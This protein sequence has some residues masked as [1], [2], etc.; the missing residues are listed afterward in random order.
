MPSSEDTGSLPKTAHVFDFTE[1]SIKGKICISENLVTMVWIS[2]EY[3]SAASGPH[4]AVA[5]SQ[6]SLV[7]LQS[8][9]QLPAAFPSLILL[10]C[11]KKMSSWLSSLLI[12]TN[13]QPCACSVSHLGTFHSN[14]ETWT[15]ISCL[16]IFCCHFQASSIWATSSKHIQE[17][18]S[19]TSNTGKRFKTHKTSLNCCQNIEG[20]SLVSLRKRQAV[21]Q[22][23]SVRIFLFPMALWETSSNADSW[24]CL[25]TET[26]VM[27]QVTEIQRYKPKVSYHNQSLYHSSISSV[28]EQARVFFHCKHNN[29]QV[30]LFRTWDRYLYWSFLNKE[31]SQFQCSSSIFCRIMTKPLFAL[32][33]LPRASKLYVQVGYLLFH[34][35]KHL[36]FSKVDPFQQ[37][38]FP[39]SK[40]NFNSVQQ[41][42]C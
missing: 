15:F 21:P 19:E 4:I 17:V 18:L 26:L 40:N 11:G 34:T 3:H 32:D 10:P 5:A 24:Q 7:R 16:I 23:A 14:G 8:A 12:V 35:N 13:H 42:F 29:L 20:P 30:L 33:L 22:A 28:K 25:S 6:I 27:L 41:H 38:R 2:V 31:L 1:D 9:F 37:N 39:L 36:V